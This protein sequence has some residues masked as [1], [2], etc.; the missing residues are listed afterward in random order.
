MSV[1]SR[2][3]AALAALLA[4]CTGAAGSSSAPGTPTPAGS[5]VSD[6]VE[7]WAASP[8]DGSGDIS[9]ADVTEA[10]GLVQPLLGMFGHAAAWGDV[11]GDGWLD[12]FVGSFADRPIEE[13]QVRG[14]TGP[15]PDR[16]LLGGPD[17]FR[18][19]SSFP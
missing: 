11:N 17:G 2:A 18:V 13:Y 9:F 1:R 6:G 4:S 16:L 8:A 7:C 10:N 12:L 5:V 15:S 19:D 14:A 3:V